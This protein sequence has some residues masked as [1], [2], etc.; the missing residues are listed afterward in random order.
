MTDLEVDEGNSA[1]FKIK[2]EF[3]Y[4]KA[5][6]IFYKNGKMILK[7]KRNEICNEKN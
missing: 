3:G 6:V 2:L 4:P 5:R 1:T 7:D